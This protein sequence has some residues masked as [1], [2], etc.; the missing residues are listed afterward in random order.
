MG[1][2]DGGAIV[3]EGN[4]AMR[5]NVF[6]EEVGRR[7]S[8]PMSSHTD[9]H[10]F[11]RRLESLELMLVSKRAIRVGVLAVVGSEVHKNYTDN[12]NDFDAE[13][14]GKLGGML[15]TGEHSRID[16]FSELDGSVLIT[17]HLHNVR[18]FGIN[19]LDRVDI[20]D[21]EVTDSGLTDV[22]ASNSRI[23]DCDLRNSQLRDASLSNVSGSSGQK[24]ILSGDIDDHALASTSE[25]QIIY[26][27]LRE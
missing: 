13:N 24:T 21:S 11:V 10:P 17:G 23:R 16:E 12:L 27:A 1:G 4:D 15:I 7:F 26:T 18:L 20:E 19:Y 9:Y 3:P 5:F 6:C 8:P 22:K 25:G 2:M 14:G